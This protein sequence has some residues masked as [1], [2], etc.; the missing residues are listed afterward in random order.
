MH[1]PLHCAGHGITRAPRIRPV[2]CYTYGA[3][4]SQTPLS[5]PPEAYELLEWLDRQPRDSKVGL[6]PGAAFLHERSELCTDKGERLLRVLDRAGYLE[7]QVFDQQGP[8]GLS[9]WHSPKQEGQRR[10]TWRR[11]VHRAKTVGQGLPDPRCHVTE[12]EALPKSITRTWVAEGCKPEELSAAV[13]KAKVGD[14]QVN[15]AGILLAFAPRIRITESGCDALAHFQLGK[16]PSGAAKSRRRR[17]KLGP[18]EVPTQ[19]ELE[20]YKLHQDGHTYKDIGESLGI[21]HQA[22]FTRVK[23]AKKILNAKGRSVRTQAL[24]HDK[25]GQVTSV[26]RKGKVTKKQ[27]KED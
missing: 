25:R 11:I 9:P 6:P 2:R 20:A 21:S 10:R 13:E 16:S 3:M 26:M 4:T 8:F 19:K 14:K 1:R 22:A 5:L 24:P 15:T 17:R 18:R 7:A 23:R 27:I 12:L